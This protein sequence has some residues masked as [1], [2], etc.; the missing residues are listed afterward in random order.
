MLYSVLRTAVSQAEQTRTYSRLMYLSTLSALLML[1]TTLSMG[2]SALPDSGEHVVLSPTLPLFRGDLVRIWPHLGWIAAGCIEVEPADRP[3][4][5]SI[6]C[7]VWEN[8]NKKAEFAGP[9]VVMKRVTTG[10][11]QERAR[12]W[13]ASIS[14]KPIAATDDG[15]LRIEVRMVL[16][17]GYTVTTHEPIVVIVPRSQGVSGTTSITESVS[18]CP[19]N[20]YAVWQYVALPNASSVLRIDPLERLNDCAWGV[21]MSVEVKDANEN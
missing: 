5:V 2:V 18:A 17:D 3:S 10:Q 12:K 9:G 19:S 14:L 13:E 21:V 6:N 4:L 11:D 16:Q 20:T 7:Q 8:G 15:G 1:A